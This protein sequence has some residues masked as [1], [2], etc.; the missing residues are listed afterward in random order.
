MDTIGERIKKIRKNNNLTQEQFAEKIL[1]N[2]KTIQ[3]YEQEECLPDV[4]NL[5]KIAVEFNISSDYILGISDDAVR[6]DEDSFVKI[7]LLY[8]DYKKMRFNSILPDEDY[9]WIT[10]EVKEDK[11]YITSVQTKCI[12][13]AD[14]ECKKEIRVPREVIPEKAIELC[15][16]VKGDPVIINKISEIGLYYIFGG[17]AII[18]RKL[19]EEHM[20]NIVAPFIVDRR[21]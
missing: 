18:R 12:G 8:Q 2:K 13:F 17:D 4:Y 6:S 14:E 16:K 1:C 11:T 20:P 5:K 21:G 9:Y 19:C 15:K 10:F 3:R 7:T